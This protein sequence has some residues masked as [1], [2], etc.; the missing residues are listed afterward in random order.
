MHETDRSASYSQHLAGMPVAIVDRSGGSL[1][2][3]IGI[4]GRAARVEA[5]ALGRR[6]QIG[7]RAGHDRQRVFA[8][9][10]GR[11]SIEQAL[12]VGMRRGAVD[13]CRVGPDS[14]SC[15]AYMT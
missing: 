2:V 1:A 12:R 15:A 5:A 7:Q 11:G 8:S 9:R 3:Q 13:R 14:T 4:C 6:G 10:A